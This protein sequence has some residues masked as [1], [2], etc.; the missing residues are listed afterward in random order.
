MK[1]L[2]FFVLA[3]LLAFITAC[4]EDQGLEINF[5]D[6][7]EIPTINSF[8]EAAPELI[9]QFGEEYLY[10]GNTP[11]DLNNISFKV[12]GMDY[13]FS[14]RFRFG[15]NNEPTPITT[16]PPSYD[17]SKYYHHFFE[18]FE[19]ISCHRFRSQDSH[20][21]IFIRE[22]NSYI[23][24]HDSLFTAYYIEK[25]T[26]EGSGFPTN[27]IIISGTVRNDSNGLGISNYRFGKQILKYDTAPD[28][29]TFAPGTIEIKTHQAF[30]EYCDWDS[31]TNN[32]LLVP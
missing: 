18:H 25:I 20:G 1:K 16:P 30:C 14:K 4:K 21:N 10:F 23:I 17:A 11:P 6:P 32:K 2:L 27:A 19:S 22:N 29:P 3:P 26:D 8:F 12:D 5:N 7:Q 24:G 13:V 15:P 28:N 31:L 9:E